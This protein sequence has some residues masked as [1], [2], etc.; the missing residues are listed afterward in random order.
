MRPG[1]NT[2]PEEGPPPAAEPEPEVAPAVES[3]PAPPPPP[4]TGDVT[5]TDQGNSK[6]ELEITAA[7]RRALVSSSTLSFG[8]KNAKVITT[9]TKVTLKGTV[10]SDVERA[11]IVRLARAAPGVTEVDDQLLIEAK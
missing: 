4:S 2:P 9:G 10:K 7:I 6:A 5:A 11:E 1:G 3:P 8:A